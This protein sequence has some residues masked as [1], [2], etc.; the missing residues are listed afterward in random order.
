LVPFVAGSS[1][2]RYRQFLIYNA[3]GGILWTVGFVLLGYSLGASWRV[4]EQWVGR[5]G[6]V[7][8]SALVAAA[9]GVWFWPRRRRRACTALATTP[10]WRTMAGDEARP[11]PPRGA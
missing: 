9:I 10:S 4:A 1:R 3:A 6:L 11:R 5:A 7:I 8:G 2:M